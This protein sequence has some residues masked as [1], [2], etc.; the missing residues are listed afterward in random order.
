VGVA[1]TLGLVLALVPVAKTGA[2]YDAEAQRLEARGVAA[3]DPRAP[4][5]D[6]ARIKAERGA[7]ADA[8]AKLQKALA[9]LGWRGDEAAQRKVL[10]SATGAPDYGADGSVVITLS[11]ST[12]GLTLKR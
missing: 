2:A 8:E 6:V 7:R 5:A 3:A 4:S 11:I 10:D 12:A 9:A 1:A